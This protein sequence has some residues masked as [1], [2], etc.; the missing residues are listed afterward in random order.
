MCLCDSFAIYE[1]TKRRDAHPIHHWAGNR[2]NSCLSWNICFVWYLIILDVLTFYF[3]RNCLSLTWE[4]GRERGR[5]REK[6]REGERGREKEG[7]Y[8]LWATPSLSSLSCHITAL[9]VFNS[10]GERSLS[11][12]FFSH[13]HLFSLWF[14]TFSNL[15]NGLSLLQIQNYFTLNPFSLFRSLLSPLIFNVSDMCEGCEIEP[16]KITS[17]G[18]EHDSVCI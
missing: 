4:R 2:N 8:H 15:S 7:E 5:G 18:K 13:S 9:L 16:E 3:W 14:L 6:K 17:K 11:L 10:F 1:I 12:S